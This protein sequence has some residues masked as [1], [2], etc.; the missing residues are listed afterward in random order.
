MNKIKVNRKRT[1]YE[2]FVKRFLDIF[3]ALMALVVF[4]LLY[5]IIALLVRI[6]LGKPII[7][8]QARPGLIDSKSGNEKIFYLYKFRTMTN[9]KDK[10]GMLLPDELRLTKFGKMLRATSLD[11]IPEVFNVLK[12]EMSIV[13]PRP[14]LIK[15]LVF[16]DDDQRR[17]HLV[18]PGISGL[19]QVNGRNAIS[20]Y[21]KFAWDNKYVSNISF[22]L[23][24]K[25]VWLTFKQ[26]FIRKNITKSNEEIDITLNYGEFLLQSGKITQDY[27]DERIRNINLL[28]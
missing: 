4:S 11:E 20:W 2:K 22:S 16:M 23:D 6:K 26:V 15:D 9:Q 28:V 5:I 17:R 25:I 18:K 27:Y 24:V 13:G 10:D 3:C 19:A 14:Q 21:D 1:F 12:G 8:K 7:F